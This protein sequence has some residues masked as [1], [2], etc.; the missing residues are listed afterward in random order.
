VLVGR[1]GEEGRRGGGETS[2]LYIP[3][4]ISYYISIIFMIL[5][6]HYTAMVGGQKLCAQVQH[7]T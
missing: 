2:L 3:R 5:L 6:L 7:S 4:V 1:G